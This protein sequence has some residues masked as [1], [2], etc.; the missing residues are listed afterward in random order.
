MLAIVM[1]VMCFS[2]ISFSGDS[3][4]KQ[5]IV[6]DPARKLM[7]AE[8]PK[9]PYSTTNIVLF[10][11]GLISIGLIIANWQTK[12]EMINF[13]KRCRKWVRIT[14]DKVIKFKAN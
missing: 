14:K 1:C 2:S 13:L 4:G 9:S 5:F 12:E 6:E 11:L 3:K 10:I 7:F 8:E